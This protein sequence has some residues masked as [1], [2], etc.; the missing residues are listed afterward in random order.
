MKDGGMQAGLTVSEDWEAEMSANDNPK[1]D[2]V[3]TGLVTGIVQVQ[4][5]LVED[6]KCPEVEN[7]I[8]NGDDW[9]DIFEESDE[10]DAVDSQNEVDILAI[11]LDN[12][13]RETAEVS[14]RNQSKFA[15][16]DSQ[17]FSSGNSSLSDE[18]FNEYNSATDDS[19][20]LKVRSQS[21]KVSNNDSSNKRTYI[22]VHKTDV[23]FGTSGRNET[24]GN[25]VCHGKGAIS[26]T[27]PVTLW[28]PES[29]KQRDRRGIFDDSDKGVELDQDLEIDEEA[30][31]DTFGDEGFGSI[32]SIS[33]FSKSLPENINENTGS[34]G[35]YEAHRRDTRTTNKLNNCPSNTRRMN[36]SVMCYNGGARCSWEPNR[37][38]SKRC[39][40]GESLAFPVCTFDDDSS[41][42]VGSNDSSEQ[43]GPNLGVDNKSAAKPASRKKE[44]RS[45]SS[46]RRHIEAEAYTLFE[47]A[48]A[49]SQKATGKD[50]GS[51]LLHSAV[52]DDYQI[53]PNR[54]LQLAAFEI[55]LFALRLHNRI[56]PKWL[57]RTYSTH[58]SWIASQAAEI[59]AT[60]LQALNEHWEGVLTPA[61]I[62]DISSRASRSGDPRTKRSAAELAL[63][64]LPQAHTLNPGEIHNALTLCREQDTEML[65]RA[66]SS[67]E[68]AARY[69]GIH[70]E[71]L[72]QLARQWHYLHDRLKDEN[73]ARPDERSDARNE[74]KRPK[75][76]VVVTSSG[77][78]L[79]NSR[80]NLHTADQMSM[81]SFMTPEQYVQEQMHQQAQEFLSRQLRAQRGGQM[82]SE[83]LSPYSWIYPPYLGSLHHCPLPPH[84]INSRNPP[85][86]GDIFNAPWIN[87]PSDVESGNIPRY[88]QNAYRVGMK[89]LE[90]L[91]NRMPEDRPEIKYA[92]SPPCSDDIRWLCALAA[93]LGPHYLREFCSVVISAVYSPYVLHDLALES[94]RHFA[95]YNPAQLSSHLRSPSVSPIVQK[96]L[97]MYTELVHRELVLL[98]QAGY[99]DFVDL[100]RRAR[101]AFCMAPG[102]MTKFNELLEMIR[103]TYSKKRELWQLIMTGL[104]RA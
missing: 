16:S 85:R 59:G 72:F 6:E 53:R 37:N 21:I 12:S 25:N 103:K 83:E 44:L 3:I 24:P 66:C 52:E 36:S 51:S 54:P 87:F 74:Q 26:K 95:L 49:V 60:A 55:A 94:A 45:V 1:E 43:G 42:C 47:L 101:S 90:A 20:L 41:E 2:E 70:P 31:E 56:S 35:A 32:K 17:D 100:L 63:S 48:K 19:P 34:F 76:P 91:A 82:P 27:M 99:N 57:S 81:V 98:S 77:R 71:L 40:T 88:L 30:K 80:T 89:A 67:I 39:D 4:L 9:R 50:D 69:G 68:T 61:E 18:K 14:A 84:V 58:V 93:S 15:K 97:A 62:V 96:S 28:N 78:D 38:G 10:S 92:Q 104:S 22:E 75:G 102:G 86:S 23:T 5:S 46:D 11:K 13:C 79:G 65:E 33:E 64:C 7:E 29:R 73:E 8:D